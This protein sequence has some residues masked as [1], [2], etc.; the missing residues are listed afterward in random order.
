MKS[1]IKKM[2]ISSFDAN[3][4]VHFVPNGRTVNQAF[5]LKVLKRLRD[6]VRGK[7]PELWQSGELWLHH[8]NAPTHKA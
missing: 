5:Y 8:D 7:R 1:K 2:L 6:P 4:N 3:G